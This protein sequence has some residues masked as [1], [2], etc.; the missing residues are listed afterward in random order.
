M[1]SSTSPEEQL[2]AE[3]A[4]LRARLEE[5]EETL[6][7]IR[8]GEVDSLVVETAEGPQ[9][10]T[11]NSA[12]Q[13]S[14][15]LRGDILAQVTDAVGMI[16][17][18]ER[19]V[20]LNPALER[21]YGVQPGEM[22]GR[23]LDELY[24]RRWLKPGDEAAA[25]AALREAGAAGWELI[26]VTRDGRE[27][28]V[29]SSVALM[30]DAAGKVTGTIAAICD[31]SERRAIEEKLRASEER[32]G[33]AIDAAKMGTWDW[34]MVTGEILWSPHHE[35]TFGYEPGTPHRR[36]ADFENRLHPADAERVAAAVREAVE[37]QTEFRSEYRVVWPEGSVHWIAG[38]G[39]FQ[40][41]SDGQATRMIGIVQDISERKQVEEHLRASEAFNRTMLESNPDCVKVLDGAGRLQFM[42]ANGCALLEIDDFASFRG[43]QW[44]KLWPEAS[45]AAVQAAVARAGGGETVHFQMF[46]P[47]AKATPKWWDVIVTPVP[48]KSGED[49][50]PAL[51][52][53]SR[54]VTAQHAA[55]EEL[56]KSEQRL[57][58]GTEVAELALAEVD[59][60]TGLNLLTVRAA[61]LF[62]LGEAAMAVPRAA[63]HATFHP[64]DREELERR[65]AQC[66]DPAGSGWFAMEHRVVWPGGEVRW[67]SVRKQVFFTGEGP[68]RR[69][70]MA[71]LAARDVTAEKA[72]AEALQESE[73]RFRILAT[74]MPQ[75][76]WV[77]SSEGEC[78]FQGPQ[79]ENATGQAL[80]DSLGYGWLEMIHPEDRERTGEIWQKAV[81]ERRTYEAEYR[82]R[83]KQGTYRWYLARAE[84]LTDF[85][86][87]V[88]H[89]IGTSTD[90]DDAKRVAALTKENEQRMRLATEATAVGIWEWNV[91]TGAIRWDA[92]MFRL[93]GLAPTA[94][95]FVQYSDWT[96][97]VLPEDLPE[98]ERILQDTVR[99]GGQSRRE[100]RILRRYD[101]ELRTIEAVETVRTNEHGQAEWVVGTNL[102][103]TERRQA[104][105]AL[106]TSEEKLRDADRTKDE[107]L[108][109]LAHELRNPL[110]PVRNSLELLKWESGNTELLKQARETMERQIGHM[111]RL[112]DDLLDVSR[113]SRNKLELKKERIELASVI[114]HAVEA[115]QPHFDYANHEFFLTLPAE[116]IHLQGDPTRLAQV[117]GN[118]LTN[119]CKYSEPGGK[120]WLTVERDASEVQTIVKD[121]GI[122]IPPEMLDKVFN[123][124]T[125][126][127]KSLERSDGGL[128]IGLSLVKRLVELHG[129]TVTARCEG[130]GHGSEFTVRLPCEI[131]QSRIESLVKTTVDAPSKSTG[132]RVLIVDDNRDSATSLALLLK[133]TGNQTKTAFDGLEALATAES[134]QPNVILLDIGLPKM[135]GH[136]TCRAIRQQPWGKDILILALTGWGQEE[137]RR[138]T[139]EAGFDNHLVKPV[140]YVA[141]NKLILESKPS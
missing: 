120:I 134:F 47:T 48:G 124:F 107:F 74:S 117:I 38:F 129:G 138:R 27:L 3:N 53:V 22:L 65:I 15:R 90:I 2:R 101:G 69:P 112:I 81:A 44:G 108:A 5:A 106:R 97:A 1:T 78:T 139:A 43:Q 137:D 82:L 10:F 30:H 132:C 18:D 14:N 128:G 85:P 91:H 9:I 35:T 26:H 130:L 114:H 126:I 111:V 109:T 71:V 66:L 104:E 59:Y 125:Q 36:Y 119:A 88:Q 50:A 63:V 99:G 4:L 8:S 68:E 29:Q 51:L 16:D 141:L 45:Q 75:L 96:R 105:A 25:M 92:Q 34:D 133:I 98:T 89:W 28:H 140:D 23:K 94:D 60:T 7:A 95:G 79:W 32:Q 56:R 39:R 42:N 102:D 33:L 61:R 49:R 11:L 123:M 24:Q 13:A 103:V 136:D 73:T 76:V 110:A 31:I 55:E 54:D 113:I 67:I 83:T 37:Q 80:A 122:G 87:A 115:C 19:I 40:F 12:D 6:R 135:N 64:E 121:T 70:A 118:L 93:Y 131:E 84:M 20:F 100:F 21:L 57:A 77:C 58:L 52:S 127:D 17:N 72:A 41:D 62:G 46:G 86:G 116:P